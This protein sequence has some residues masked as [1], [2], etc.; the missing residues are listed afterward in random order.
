[1]RMKEVNVG[2]NRNFK[3]FN[4]CKKRYRLAKGSAGSGKS[5][6]IAQNFIIKLGDP[7]YKGANLL[8]VRKVDT[9][10]KDSTYAELK[11]AI[12]KIYGDKAGLFWQI[13]SNPMELISKVTGNKVI[14]RGMKDDGQREKVKSITF[15]VGKL[16]WI[17]IE[18][19]T[20]LY[21][22]DVDILDDRL[23][24]DLSFNPFLYYQITFSFN[25]VSATHW[26]KAK[27]L[28]EKLTKFLI[29]FS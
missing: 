4:E 13:R 28:D 6:N 7:K 3:E 8:C 17:W 10:N 14:F 11:S 15:D 26:L 29:I 5:V 1:M 18:E 24:G 25:P 16:T 2:F 20:E 9:T 22:A 23:R 27:Y 21:E 19:A 12:Y